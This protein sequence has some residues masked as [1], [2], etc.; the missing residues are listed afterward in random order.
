M[1]RAAVSVRKLLRISG[2]LGSSGGVSIQRRMIR[3]RE[4][5]TLGSSSVSDR[6]CST[7]VNASSSQKS[8]L[9]EALRRAFCSGI[10]ADSAA[11]ASSSAIAEFSSKLCGT[12][13]GC[14][15]RNYR[16]LA[17]G[18]SESDRVLVWALTEIVVAPASDSSQ[19]LTDQPD[20]FG[21]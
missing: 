5:P 2:V 21:I 4:G 14:L 19:D 17:H 3:S 11:W 6:F 15:Q 13:L 10:F 20:V 9:R 7:R 1:A 8:A 16:L 18:G 12:E